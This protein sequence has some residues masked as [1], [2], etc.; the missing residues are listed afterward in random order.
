MWFSDI[1][2]ALATS[3][4]GMTIMTNAIQE[5]TSHELDKVSGGHPRYLPP[6][7]A[8]AFAKR[9]LELSLEAQFNALQSFKMP[10]FF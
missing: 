9:A 8:E 4:K 3:A 1:E 5:L 2:E 10:S 6:R 7:L